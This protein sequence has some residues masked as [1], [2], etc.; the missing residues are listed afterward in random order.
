MVFQPSFSGALAVSFQESLK[1]HRE[2]WREL[3]SVSDHKASYRS[4]NPYSN[5][6][7]SEKNEKCEKC[8]GSGRGLVE[9]PWFWVKGFTKYPTL[10]NISSVN[11]VFDHPNT[12][13]PGKWTTFEKKRNPPWS[14]IFKFP[15]AEAFAWQKLLQGRS[16]SW[17]FRN[18]KANHLWWNMMV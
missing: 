15:N 18:P 10:T 7:I 12:H 4:Q 17:Y 8:V 14:M 9:Q 11:N 2:H 5:R 1:H 13:R 3:L 6:I 16:Y